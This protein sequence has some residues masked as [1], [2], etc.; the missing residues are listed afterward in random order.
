[1]LTSTK[2]RWWLTAAA[3]VTLAGLGGINAPLPSDAASADEGAVLVAARQ[4]WHQPDRYEFSVSATSVRGLVPGARKS[5]Q[6]T[7]AD[8]YR[9]PID[10]FQVK[11]RLISTSRRGCAPKPVNLEV[12]PYAGRLPVRISA[13]GRQVA[14]QISLHMPNSVAEAC[15]KAVFTIRI[16]ASAM[17]AGTDPKGNR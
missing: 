15:Q 3:A 13:N 14:G 2:R 8:P 6:L 5:I 16:S 10:V 11:G 4:P 17:K 1:M 12:L 9:F 7:F